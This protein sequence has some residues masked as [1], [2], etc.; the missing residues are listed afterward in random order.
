MNR[1]R[2]LWPLLLTAA[3]ALG[4]LAAQVQ[5]ANIFLPLV[6]RAS[7]GPTSSGTVRVEN[8]HCHWGDKEWYGELV[9][10]TD[11]TVSAPRVAMSLLD[12]GGLLVGNATGYSMAP[13]LAPGERTPFVVRWYN[14]PGDWESYVISPEWD[15]VDR[16]S[17]ESAL[18]SS[19]KSGWWIMTATVCNQLPVRVNSVAVGMVVYGPSGEVI[20]YDGP[21]EVL[22]PLDPGDTLVVTHNFYWYDW[23][24]EDEPVSCAAF[25]VP[26]AA[27][28]LWLTDLE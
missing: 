7:T 3:F 2:V 8:V 18:R 6:A 11:C 15:P 23:E 26:S 16:L 17:V 25:A 12:E 21:R 19:G 27:Y 28:Q 14:H 9:N 4:V 1:K 5:A 20:G 24:G 22:G 10:E 13:L